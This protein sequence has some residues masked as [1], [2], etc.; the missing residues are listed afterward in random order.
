MPLLDLHTHSTCSDGLCS[1]RELVDLAV[2]RGLDTIALTDHDTT[3]GNREFMAHAGER[4]IRGIAGVE[5]S[6]RWKGPGNCHIVGLG[7]P[8][9]YAPLQEVL[10]RTRHSRDNRIG[11]IVAK[12][13]EHGVDIEERDIRRAARGEVMTRPHVAQALVDRG[14]VSTVDEAF[15][16]LLYKGGPGYVD[17]FRLEP[18]E[19]VSL[20]HRAG[21][22]VVLAHPDQLRIQDRDIRALVEK[23]I[24]HGLGGIEVYATS[25][26][27]TQIEEYLSI[28][29]DYHLK[30]TG[31]SDFHGESKPE[32]ILGCYRPDVP[33]PGEC[34]EG[35]TDGRR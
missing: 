33:V 12:L 22:L 18:E 34:L 24:P 17:R 35:G 6:A 9:D 4:G 5:I 20:L 26:S 25:C 14:I 32:H 3:D 1:P 29:R 2:A 19:A 27:D 13:R 10:A 15:D 31:G 30:V 7:V 8:H 11:L 21:A 16:R 23:L 28:A